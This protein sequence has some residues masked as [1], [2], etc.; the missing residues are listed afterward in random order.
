MF[1]RYGA[2]LLYHYPPRKCPTNCLLSLV[3]ELINLDVSM[4]TTFEIFSLLTTF[5]MIP[6][7]WSGRP[8]S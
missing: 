4:L 6:L 3:K 1:K 8:Y 2:G 5:E 7:V